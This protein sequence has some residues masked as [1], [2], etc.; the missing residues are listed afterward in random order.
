MT[1]VFPSVAMQDDEAPF[2]PRAGALP[3]RW[4]AVGVLNGVKVFEHVGAPIPHDL[5]VGLDLTP[6]ETQGLSNKEGVPIQLPRRTRWLT[7]FALGVQVGM[8]FDISLAPEVD[9]FDE[10]FVFGVCITESPAQSAQSL[11]ELFTGHRFSRGLAFVAQNTPTNNSAAGGSG[12]PSQAERINEGF[13][14]ERRPRTFAP[15]LKSNGRAAA[16]AFGASLELFAQVSRSGATAGVA[17]EPEG[18]EPEASHAMQTVLWPV[19]LGSFFED[20][21]QLSA[22]R[23]NALRAY[24]LEHVRASGPI[25]A[26]PATVRRA[27]CHRTQRFRCRAVG[28]H[29][30][31]ASAPAQNHSHVVR[32]APRALGLQRLVGRCLA[33]TGPVVTSVR[34]DH[35]TEL[36]SERREPVGLAGG[37]A[38]GRVSQQHPGYVAYRSH[39]RGR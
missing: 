1:P 31:D 18:F 10:L 24:F 27:A 28:R 8:A 32:D 22:S 3:D 19:T 39:L 2:V 34:R 12:L 23:V 26:M 20:F 33:A 30:R 25:P 16:R 5:A 36:S 17:T 9:R 37:L 4:I 29:R 15:D 11:A 35:A 7:D 13:V 6:A 14:L 38:G 21:L